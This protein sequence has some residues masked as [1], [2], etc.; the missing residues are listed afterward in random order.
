MFDSN[1]AYGE[2]GDNW[3]AMAEVATERGA[4][5]WRVMLR[6]PVMTEETGAGDPFHNVVGDFPSA[7]T[8]W[9]FNIGRARVRGV[10]DADHTRFAFAPTGTTTY[11]RK[12]RFVRLVVE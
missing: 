11:H 1:R 10:S 12:E 9:F 6:L 5:F 7:D 4:D 8:P 2:R 3:S